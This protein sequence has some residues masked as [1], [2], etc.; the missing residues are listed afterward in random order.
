MPSTPLDSPAFDPAAAHPGITS[1]GSAHIMFDLCNTMLTA[2]E[3]VCLGRKLPWLTL[4]EEVLLLGIKD[5]QG[6]L[7]FW[8]ANIL[9]IG[10]I[11]DPVKC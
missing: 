9:W 10:I 1:A 7:S 3:D 4:M 8:N 2:G 6:Y 5:K 11:R